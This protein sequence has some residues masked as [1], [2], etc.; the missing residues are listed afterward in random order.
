M[1]ASLSFGD[2]LDLGTNVKQEPGLGSQHSGLAAAATPDVS[3]TDQQG[4]V[5]VAYYVCHHI[6][7]METAMLLK[8]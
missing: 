5:G 1:D 7:D 4:T 6:S 2:E 3:G 8:L